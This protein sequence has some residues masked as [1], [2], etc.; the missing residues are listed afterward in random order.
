MCSPLEEFKENLAK[1]I[2]GR[3]R[4]DAGCVNCGQVPKGFRDV[5]SQKE[6]KLSRYCQKCQDNFFGTGGE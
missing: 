4:A 3:S 1:A 6:W 5:V 2:H